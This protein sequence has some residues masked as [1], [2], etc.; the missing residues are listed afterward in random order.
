MYVVCRSSQAECCTQLMQLR[1]GLAIKLCLVFLQQ[2]IAGERGAG[3]A[4]C[5]LSGSNYAPVALPNAVRL[6][7]KPHPQPA[8]TDDTL[9][10][11]ASVRWDVK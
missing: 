11:Q 2:T 9:K 5:A 4:Q 1:S 8:F 6:P 7:E 3:D 10:F